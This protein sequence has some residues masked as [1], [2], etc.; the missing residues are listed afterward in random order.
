MGA[1]MYQW[2]T[3]AIVFS[4]ALFGCSKRNPDINRVID[5]YWEKAY[6]NQAWETKALSPDEWYYRATVVDAPPNTTAAPVGEGHWL[7]PDIVRFEITEGY[8][9]GWR[10][11]SSMRGADNEEGKADYK[12]VPVAVFKITDQ[13]DITRGFNSTTLEESNVLSE[14][15]DMPWAKRR[16]IRVDFSQNLVKKFNRQDGFSDEEAA[17]LETKGAFTVSNSDPAD[18]RRYRFHDGRFD[19]TSRQ[20]VSMDMLAY[21]GLYGDGFKEDLGAP[22]VDIRHAFMKRGKADYEPLDYPDSV[23]QLDDQRKA[24]RDEKGFEKRLPIW[25]KF[26]FFRTNMD[27]RLVNDKKHGLLESNKDQYIT[28]FNIWETTYRQDGSLIPIEERKPKPIIYYTNVDHPDNL[29]STSQEVASEWD[30]VF[31]EVVFHAQPG[32]YASIEAVPPMFVLHENSCNLKNVSALFDALNADKQN[33]I[34][35]AAKVDLPTIHNQIEQA[36]TIQD[37]TKSHDQE[38]LAKAQLERVC[39]AM[40]YY[41]MSEK[42]PFEYQRVGT[43]GYNM[44]N[45]ITKHLQTRWS[46]FGPMFSDPI[47]GET[48]Q[49]VANIALHHIDRAAASAVERLQALNG[50]T[51]LEELAFGEKVPEIVAENIAHARF[52]ARL[53]PSGRA[54]RRFAREMPL[55]E[56]SNAAP[57]AAFSAIVDARLEEKMRDP[58]SGDTL[59]LDRAKIAKLPPDKRMQFIRDQLSPLHSLEYLEPHHDHHHDH[60]GFMDSVEMVDNMIAG[61]G[62][63]YKDLPPKEQFKRIRA[64]VFKATALH[65]IGHNM[66][67]THNM[68]GSSDALH[69]GETFWKSQQLPQKLEEALVVVTDGKMREALNNCLQEN[70]KLVEISHKFHEDFTMTTQD[71]L[72]QQEAMYSSI[73]DYHANWN[74]DFNGLGL[75]DKAAIHFGYA[76]L[77]EVFPEENILINVR[78]TPMKR[79]LF[80]NDW[81]KIPSKLFASA[82]KI[83]QRAYVKYEWNKKQTQFTPPANEVPYKFCDDTSSYHN[84][85]CRA[86][87]FGPDMSSQ[88]EF[89]ETQYWKD[90]LFTHFAR[91]RLWQW[92]LAADRL[93]GL[94]SSHM[95]IYTRMMQ[96]YYFYKATDPGFSGSDSEKDYLTAM[97]MGLNHFGHV[98]GHPEPGVFTTVPNFAVEKKIAI[99]NDAQ[100]LEPSSVMISTS[101]VDPCVLKNVAKMKDKKNLQSIGSHRLASAF[102]GMGRPLYP[103]V[104]HGLESRY[105]NYMGTI[106]AKFDAPLFLS[107][108][109]AYFPKMEGMS[110]PRAYRV[111]WYRLFPKEVGNILYNLITENW[112]GLGYYVDD[113]GNV[114]PRDVINVETLEAHTTQPSAVLMPTTSSVL[115]Y[116]AM[117][118]SAMFLSGI[119][120][121]EEDMGSKMSVSTMA[122]DHFSHMMSSMEQSRVVSYSNPLVGHTYKAAKT[123]S[124][125]IAYTLVQNAN[126]LKERYQRLDMCIKDQDALKQDPLCACPVTRM[127]GMMGKCC[128]PENAECPQIKMQPCEISKLQEKRDEAMERLN[129]AETFLDDMHSIVSNAR[130]NP[131]L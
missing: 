123:E 51:S 53:R 43:L 12:G 25:E 24:I 68:A 106:F 44:F 57:K 73:M 117:A 130:N 20:P 54:A 96:W 52:Q 23:V 107:Y 86:F 59:M 16:F 113:N 90:Y 8:L 1:R 3:F 104:K 119:M 131:R 98:L 74:S 27:G 19:V 72:R 85:Y 114:R 21:L 60:V 101:D 88:A 2:M 111:S 71:C 110:D 91:D 93:V 30:K 75:Y 55:E 33:K 116:R 31:R 76:Q 63:Q 28:R 109:I 83:H 124:Y 120:H 56:I 14:N 36:K 35:R 125:P 17:A 69:Y 84:P 47:T 48:I 39:S 82:D 80:L 108:P 92:P 45:V 99:Q 58:Q 10:S 127:P 102:L 94:D 22:I 87:D 70:A 6:F 13:F 105:L 118:F 95:S 34:L 89:M 115:A 32:K 121:E 7:H 61:I 81:R 37:F 26:G 29:L 11:Y 77:A 4:V 18:P 41:T 126:E 9:I 129:V 5:P 38:A 62:L 122:E 42:T 112:A 49:A 40:E 67:L 66:G 79:W 97:A 64:S 103:A 50:N 100:R 78:E 46:G 65:E 128:S 15:R